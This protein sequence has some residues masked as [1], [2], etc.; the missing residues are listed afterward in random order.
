MT[1]LYVIAGLGAWIGA[2][3][4]VGKAIQNKVRRESQHRNRGLGRHNPKTCTL[5][6]RA[7]AKRRRKQ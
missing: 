3:A 2:W 4:T 7:A 5:C 6:M 1:A